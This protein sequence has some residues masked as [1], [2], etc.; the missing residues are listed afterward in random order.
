MYNKAILIGR[1]TADPEI[2]QTPS[3]AAVTSFS[4]AV[5]RSYD[6]KITDFINIVAWQKSAEFISK[7]FYKGN[8]IGIEGNIQTRSYK[9]RQGNNR[10]AFEVVAEKVFFVES[11]KSKEGDIN[12]KPNVDDFA[13]IGEDDDLPF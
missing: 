13:E 11:K 8:A 12:A 5:N 9:D 3:G 7:Y 10:T 1:L 2:K 6:R 4:I